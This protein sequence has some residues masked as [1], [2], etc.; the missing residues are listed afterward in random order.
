M[1]TKDG[2]KG[3]VK[4]L[5]ELSIVVVGVAITFTGN[6]WFG[7]RNEKKEMQGYLDVLQLEL[8]E[9]LK[10]LNEKHTFYE[11][12]AKFTQYLNSDE[13]EN[14]SQDSL[15]QYRYIIGRIPMISIKTSSFEML[16]MS[17]TMRLIKDKDFLKSIL[18]SYSEMEKVKQANDIYMN[19]KFDEIF[20]FILDNNSH[21]IH[22]ITA[23]DNKRLFYFYAADYDLY[24][25]FLECSQQVEKTLS[26]F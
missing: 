20:K 14:L 21:D 24:K 26:L 11:H 3:I 5:R 15:K 10:S 16:K 1:K 6:D 4:Y 9:N 19:R 25:V 17:G 2:F 23:P 18:D 8:E 22:N 7:S 13:P 12:T